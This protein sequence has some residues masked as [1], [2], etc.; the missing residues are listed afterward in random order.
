MEDPEIIYS[1]I[2]SIV[3]RNNFFDLINSGKFAS[4]VTENND[5]AYEKEGVWY[6]PAFRAGNL[7]LDA[8]GGIGVSKD[9]VREFLDKLTGG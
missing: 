8:K 3:D 9:E 2:K 7:K 5:L 6:V 1:I 4:K